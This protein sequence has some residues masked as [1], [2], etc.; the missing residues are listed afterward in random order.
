MLEKIEEN[1]GDGV[2]TKYTGNGDGGST[3]GK[4]AF[5]YSK[6]SEYLDILNIMS[7]DVRKYV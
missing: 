6:F 1:G 3:S 5:T 4:Y 7:V 2:L